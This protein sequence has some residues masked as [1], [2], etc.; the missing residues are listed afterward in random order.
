VAVTGVVSKTRGVWQV[1]N[2]KGLGVY[3]MQRNL[4]SYLNQAWKQKI[5]T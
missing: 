3:C 5:W 2:E 1:V 4:L